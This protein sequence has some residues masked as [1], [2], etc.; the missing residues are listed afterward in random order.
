[1][2]K[3]FCADPLRQ[4]KSM[5]LFI[6]LLIVLFIF[7]FLFIYF[8]K[9]FDLICLT[10]KLNLQKQATFLLHKIHKLPYP[11]SAPK[12]PIFSRPQRRANFIFDQQ[13]R[14]Q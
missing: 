9:H 7:L 6:Y 12:S 8:N 14:L 11:N 5:S 2:E 4:I 3:V 1:M 13:I 10:E